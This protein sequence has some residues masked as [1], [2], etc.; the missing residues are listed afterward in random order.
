MRRPALTGLQSVTGMFDP[1]VFAIGGSVDDAH[2]QTNR[3]RE[4]IV[5]SMPGQVGCCERAPPKTRRSK[6]VVRAVSEARRLQRGVDRAAGEVDDLVFD[7][8]DAAAVDP[9]ARVRDL[10]RDRP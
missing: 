8:T 4:R 7:E 9:V 10:L 6:N 1:G 5:T 2:A 3:T